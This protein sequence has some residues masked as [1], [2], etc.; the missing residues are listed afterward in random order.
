MAS[1][2]HVRRNWQ[3]FGPF[4]GEQIRKLAQQGKLNPGD[5]IWNDRPETGGMARDFE[6]LGEMMAQAR[7]RKAST[8]VA[9]PPKGTARPNASGN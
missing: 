6:G 8:A 2:W 7:S 9:T 4:T 1:T 3:D 5:F